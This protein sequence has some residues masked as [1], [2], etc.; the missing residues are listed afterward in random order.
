MKMNT[1][2]NDDEN[3]ENDTNDATT[4]MDDCYD[5]FC[6]AHGDVLQIFHKQHSRKKWTRPKHRSLEHLETATLRRLPLLDWIK[7]Y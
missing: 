1:I 5:H 3:N 4:I 7:V 2:N 6:V